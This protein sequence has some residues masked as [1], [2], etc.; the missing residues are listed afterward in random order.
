MTP[1]SPWHAVADVLPELNTAVQA[2]HEAPNG[3]RTHLG[4]VRL[5][6]GD[7]GGGYWMYGRTA[8]RM[9]PADRLPTHWRKP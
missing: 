1:E 7:D 4:E 9:V 2:V 5:V 6:K 8:Y 3:H